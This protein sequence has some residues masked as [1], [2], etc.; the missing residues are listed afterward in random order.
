MRHNNSEPEDEWFGKRL[1]ALPGAKIASNFGGGALAL[2]SLYTER[3]MGYQVR[4]GGFGLNDDVWI[5]PETRKQIFDYCPELSMIMDMKLERERCPGD[6]GGGN[7]EPLNTDDGGDTTEQEQEEESESHEETTSEPPDV[8]P[9]P[10]SVNGPPHLKP[11]P[12]T[13]WAS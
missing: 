8:P 6:D 1:L 12:T 3:P 5:D 13:S 10:M 9:L 4:S 7:I 11:Q 2:E